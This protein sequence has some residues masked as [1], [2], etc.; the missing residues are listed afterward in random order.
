MSEQTRY[1]GID[2][3]RGV[4]LCMILIDHMPGNAFEKLTVRNF[5]FS[6]AAEAFVFL[7]GLSIALAYGRRFSGERG[8]TLRSLGRRV[9]KLYGAH[10]GLSLAALAIFFVGAAWEAK[11]DLLNVHG[12]DLFVDNPLPGFLGLASLGHQL[13]Y[14]NILPLY[15][16]LI[17][18]T[19]VVFWLAETNGWLMLGC[20]ASIYALSRL[21]DWNFPSW[22]TPG[23]W[24]FDP[25]AWQMLFSIGI[26]IGLNMREIT[27]PVSRRLLAL[28]ACVVGAGLIVVTGGLGFA[29]G[30]A[31]TARADLDLSK[32]QLGL[33]RLIH[34][35]AV[36]YLIYGSALT[37]RLR[38]LPFYRPAALLGRH[39]LWVF[40]IV[41]LV[42][43]V[44]QALIEE[45]P[46]A[47]WFDASFVAVSMAIAY[48][49]ARFLERPASRQPKP[50]RARVKPREG[51]AGVH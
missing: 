31:A 9:L 46:H 7:S 28:A 8:K 1:D 21:F 2:F 14:F 4:V 39:S 27:L 6:D 13:G 34:F 49:A 10:I 48:V 37:A 51:L 33:M 12:R 47:V 41:S 42:S 50:V 45:T 23:N 22:P 29:E 20:S 17:A 32:T 35:L 18:W 40:A 38:G 25:F 11:P 3:W 26:A 36:A 15:I 30:F 5:G 24:F 44:W 43:A 16:I 19:P